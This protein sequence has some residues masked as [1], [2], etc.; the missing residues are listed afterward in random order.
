MPERKDESPL[1]QNR[2][3]SEIRRETQVREAL[4]IPPTGDDPKVTRESDLFK[5]QPPQGSER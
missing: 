3:D 4:G 1:E 2:D 5:D